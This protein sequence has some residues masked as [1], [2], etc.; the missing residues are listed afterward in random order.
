[1]QLTQPKDPAQRQ[2]NVV[3]KILP[4]MI[5][6]FSLNVP[7]ALCIYWFVNNIVTTTTTLI[8]RNS[9]DLTPVSTGGGGSAA[10]SSSTD[11]TIFAPP[12]MRE[13]PAG[14][15]SRDSSSAVD[16][17][18]VK[19]ITSNAIDAEIESD[20]GGDEE[21]EMS[22][23]ETSGEGMASESKPKKVRRKG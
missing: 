1:M 16:S 4:V 10:A 15:G 7:A 21:E 11:S 2:D 18:G 5:G 17:E 14:F 13:K 9:M 19:T 6:W 20:E 12:P 23:E 22:S 3:L 8:I